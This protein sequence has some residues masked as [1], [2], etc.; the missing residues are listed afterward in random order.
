MS[1]RQTD[2]HSVGLLSSL[3][4]LIERPSPFSHFAGSGAGRGGQK[5][6]SENPFTPLSGDL[7]AAA[8]SFVRN[9]ESAPASKHHDSPLT[10]LIAALH[11]AFRR[12]QIL[13]KQRREEEVEE[14][15]GGCPNCRNLDSCG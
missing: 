14:N 4:G 9:S 10:H 7:S 3:H 6:G 15:V 2:F 8:C 12:S 13:K 5:F 1:K 11:L